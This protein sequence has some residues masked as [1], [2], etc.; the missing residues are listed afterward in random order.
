M[1]SDGFQPIQIKANRDGFTLQLDPEADFASI[2][3]YIEQKL[4][5]S[6]DFFQRSDMILDLRARSLRT[7]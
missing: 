3:A 7:D 4:A 6:R 1:S 5:D 2:I